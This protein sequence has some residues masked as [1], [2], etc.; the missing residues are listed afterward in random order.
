MKIVFLEAGTL[1][2]D[3]E[4]D[5]FFGLGD[6]AVYGHTEPEQIGERIASADAVL[7]NKLPM[8]EETLKD[9]GF[10]KYI[11]VT[12]TGTNNVDFEYTR[13]RGITVTNVAGYSTATVAQHLRHGPLSYGASEILR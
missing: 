5:R 9:A 12:A 13:K 6:V 8:N 3:M 11:G 4:F 2:E 7:V 10:L 1:G